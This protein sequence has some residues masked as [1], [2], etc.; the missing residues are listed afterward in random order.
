MVS[1]FY[2]SIQ[3]S[4]CPPNWVLASSRPTHGSLGPQNGVQ[5]DPMNSHPSTGLPNEVYVNSIESTQ[6]GLRLF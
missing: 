6:W 3:F 4:L 5:V 2:N 1:Y